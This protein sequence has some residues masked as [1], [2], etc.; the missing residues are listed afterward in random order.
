M[1]EKRR[2]KQNREF[3]KRLDEQEE[4]EGADIRSFKFHSLEKKEDRRERTDWKERTDRRGDKK[5]FNKGG[6]SFDKKGG[7]NFGR[8][9]GRDFSKKNRRFGDDE[10]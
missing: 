1:A 8:K 2:F 5:P 6:R 4:N 9:E 7:R 10:D 3:K